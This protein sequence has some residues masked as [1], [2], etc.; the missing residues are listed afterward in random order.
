MSIRYLPGEL[1]ASTAPYYSRYRPGYA[2][3]LFDAIAERF[4]LDGTQRVLDLGTGTGALALPLAP[5]AAEVIAVDPEPG[6]LAEGQRL[7][8]EQDI[9]NID[10]RLADSTGLL[11]LDLGPVDVTVIGSA[12]HWMDRERVARDLNQIITP[13][14]AIVLAS[15][16][17]PGEV[18]P[19]PWAAVI[20]E[21]RTRYLGPER[22]A[23]SG[24]YRHPAERHQ[25]VLARGPFSHIQTARWDRTIT[26]T[27]DEVVFL[28]FSYSYSSA[29]QLGPDLRAFEADLRDALL[30]THPDGCFTELVRT[31]ALFATRP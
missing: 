24:S 1:F 6:M 31:E 8:D 2:P 10:W 28:Q 13:G 3:Q 5:L 11:T 26:R 30:A 9:G 25:D 17:A 16:P 29:I 21:V 15:G 20:A 18:E 4:G 12:F 22:R 27:L 7:A 19:P 23:G 14:G